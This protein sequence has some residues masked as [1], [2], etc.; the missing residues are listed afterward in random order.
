MWAV[1]FQIW[2]ISGL[3]SLVGHTVIICQKFNALKCQLFFFPWDAI[4][5]SRITYIKLGFLKKY[6]HELWIFSIILALLFFDLKNTAAWCVF[7]FINCLLHVIVFSKIPRRVGC[8]GPYL[9]VQVAA[10]LNSLSFI[11]LCILYTLHCNLNYSH[12]G[13]KVQWFFKYSFKP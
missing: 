12:S 7:Y 6:M 10:S 2:L 9:S 8:V 13:V 11:H 5:L 3:L 4:N 1:L